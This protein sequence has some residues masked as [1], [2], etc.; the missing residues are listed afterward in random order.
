[1]DTSPTIPSKK[2]QLGYNSSFN[3]SPCVSPLTGN[4]P[5]HHSFSTASRKSSTTQSDSTPLSSPSSLATNPFAIKYD[6]GNYDHWSIHSGSASGSTCGSAGHSPSVGY[7]SQ[8]VGYNPNSISQV[9]SSSLSLD[10]ISNSHRFSSSLR[11]DHRG[12]VAMDSAVEV[13]TETPTPLSPKGLQFRQKLF[14]PSFS[15]LPSPIPRPVNSGSSMDTSLDHA[16]SCSSA[17]HGMYLSP[18]TSLG[19]RSQSHSVTVSVVGGGSNNSSH[20]FGLHQQP[21]HHD[22][23]LSPFVTDICGHG[24]IHDYLQRTI[25]MN[26][27][28]KD[29]SN[30]KSVRQKM[31]PEPLKSS[32]AD[33]GYLGRSASPQ[34]FVPTT[35][36]L[37]ISS[38]R[39][40]L[41]TRDDF[42]DCLVANKVGADD[43][44]VR[45]IS[46][47]RR[48]SDSSFDS[49]ED[50][51][52]ESEHAVDNFEDTLGG[53]GKY[54]NSAVHS[55][56]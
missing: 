1:M 38:P 24:N 42:D 31:R 16:P 21:L 19:A 23:H 40:R 10:D 41:S 28:Q 47:K 29:L 45:Q 52:M 27:L 14:A 37:I 6:S 48:M 17:N 8:S 39:A 30:V 33:S 36:R 32:S 56:T 15:K 3:P 18:P 9:H 50:S 53:S 20:K 55:I 12:M 54:A 51:Y 49:Q 43:V 46:R 34:S 2:Q 7:S 22:K 13:L 4:S 44:R 11:D 35:S 25:H 5:L 26:R